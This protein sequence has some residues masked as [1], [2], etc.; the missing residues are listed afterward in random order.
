MMKRP[1]KPRFIKLSYFVWVIVP[2]GLWFTY[3]TI[4]LPHA[5]WSYSWIDQGQG[6]DPFAHRIYTR[7]RFIGPYGQ[8]DQPA[9]FGRCAWVKFYKMEQN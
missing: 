2:V 8:F 6:M 7:C 5:I 3:D 9:E 4:G 1:F